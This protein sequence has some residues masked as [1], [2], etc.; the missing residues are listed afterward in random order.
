MTCP[1]CETET[2]GLYER[3]TDRAL[4][5]FLCLPKEQIDLYPGWQEREVLRRRQAV[6]LRKNLG[7]THEHATN[8]VE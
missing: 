4:V 8:V 3:Q 7:R 5:C 2:D 1:K 6:Q